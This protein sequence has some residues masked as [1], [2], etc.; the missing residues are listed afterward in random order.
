MGIKLQSIKEGDGLTFPKVGQTVIVHYIGLTITSLIFVIVFVAKFVIV[1]QDDQS[2]SIGG[3]LLF[4]LNGN[5]LFH[6]QLSSR[7]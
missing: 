1:K 2:Q 5:S 4:Y 6:H 3:G 7:W